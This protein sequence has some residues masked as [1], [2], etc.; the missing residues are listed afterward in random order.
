VTIVHPSLFA[1]PVWRM[2]AGG[3]F[4]ALL[5]AICAFDIRTRRIPNR[6]VA[7]L[8][9]CGLIFSVAAPP[10]WPGLLA[11]LGGLL[12]GIAIWLPS[13]LFKLLGA[14]DV[15]MFGAAGA[16]LGMAGA[17]QGAIFGA[18]AG[19]LMALVWML[20]YR[21]MRGSALTLWAAGVHPKSLV[22]PISDLSSAPA[23]PYTVALAVGAGIA[24]CFPHLLF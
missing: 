11:G 21:G 18:F 3:V 6:L 22:Q 10:H 15:K 2:A 12:V 7:V 23:L 16:W 8:A 9:V 5:A 1:G 20:R 13:W 17:L 19:G 24:A 4:F 14:G